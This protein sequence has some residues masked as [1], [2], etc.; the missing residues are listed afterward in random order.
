ML[1]A[2]AAVLFYQRLRVVRP[3]LTLAGAL[4][5]AAGLASA[6][7]IGF[8]APSTRGY[9]P[10]HVCGE[11]QPVIVTRLEV[12]FVLPNNLQLSRLGVL[13]WERPIVRRGQ[14]T[15]VRIVGCPDMGRSLP[16]G[17]GIIL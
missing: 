11:G 9:T 5:F 3:K 8:L 12:A 7:A 16:P 15:S 2:S 6:T 1:L 13:D 4:L 10:V 17:Q 14:L